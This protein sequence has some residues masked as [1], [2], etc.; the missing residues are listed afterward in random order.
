MKKQTKEQEKKG[1]SSMA[2]KVEPFIDYQRG[3]EQGQ[4]QALK[5]VEKRFIDFNDKG[6]FIYKSVWEELKAQLEKLKWQSQAI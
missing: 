2:M 4:A 5:Q 6:Y 1:M 3:F